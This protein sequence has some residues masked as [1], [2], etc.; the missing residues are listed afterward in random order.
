MS[1]EAL[2]G[3]ITR[4][5]R[6]HQ[7]RPVRRLHQEQLSARLSEH[8]SEWSVGCRNILVDKRPKFKFTV[9]QPIP[10][11]ISFMVE[12]RAVIAPFP[13]GSFRKRQR[14]SRRVLL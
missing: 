2:I 11:P 10:C 6:R 5:P 4:R 1:G 7:K 8:S 13:P 12:P 9:I 14:F 3:I